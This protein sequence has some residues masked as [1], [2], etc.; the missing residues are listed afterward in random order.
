[1]RQSLVSVLQFFDHGP[2][3]SKSRLDSDIDLGGRQ[4]ESVPASVRQFHGV[5]VGDM[6]RSLGPV[7]TATCDKPSCNQTK[8]NLLRIC[9]IL[10]A[11]GYRT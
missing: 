2:D 10:P 3:T 1:M 7:I 11:A 6:S 4:D 5:R 9:N 8:H